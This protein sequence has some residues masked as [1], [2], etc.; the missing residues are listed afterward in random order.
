[1]QDRHAI[2][3]AGTTC[4]PDSDRDFNKWYDETHIPINMKFNGLLEVTRYQLVRS[5]DSAAVKKYPR[6]I[7]PYK[8]KDLAIFSAWNASRE[9]MEA[10][11]GSSDLFARIGVEFVWRA[12]YESIKVWENTPPLS[13][14]TIVGTQCPPTNEA[15]FDQWYSEKHIPD[16]LKFKGLQGAIRYRLAGAVGRAVKGT[17]KVPLVRNTEY[18]KFLTFLY[19]KDTA[20]ADA[21]DSSPER[22]GLLQEWIELV[23]EM[24]VTVLWRA[25]Y[26]PMRTWQR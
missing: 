21:Y 17:S 26:K 22:K 4:P 7:T 24:E 8:F 13:V 15:R 11:E 23:K 1:M 9:L 20:T 12:Q 19:F 14:I 18:P 16:L 10:S 5:S 6:F 25:Q 2:N 3:I